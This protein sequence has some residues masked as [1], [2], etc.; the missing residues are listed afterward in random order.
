MEKE[1]DRGLDGEGWK[2]ERRDEGEFKREGR[3][4]VVGR[5]EVGSKEDEV[6]RRE[7]EAEGFEERSEAVGLEVGGGTLGGRE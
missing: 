6:G 5:D 7:D 4:E 1:N 2:E 3:E